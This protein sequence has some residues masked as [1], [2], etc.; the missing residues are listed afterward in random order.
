VPTSR[1]TKKRTNIVVDLVFNPKIG[2]GALKNYYEMCDRC[3]KVF[4]ELVSLRLPISWDNPH[5]Y[6]NR[7]VG[8]FTFEVDEK[9]YLPKKKCDLLR[10]ILKSKKMRDLG[11]KSFRIRRVKETTTV[12]REFQEL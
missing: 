9:A 3:S 12:V 4:K 11:L 8:K 6:G 2:A 1:K 10:K 7:P 5:T